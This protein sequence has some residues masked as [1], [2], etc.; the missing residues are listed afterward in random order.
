MQLPDPGADLEEDEGD[1][2]LPYQPKPNVHMNIIKL[3]WIKAKT[4]ISHL[5][6]KSARW[7]VKT[8]FFR[9]LRNP[10]KIMSALL[11]INLRNFTLYSKYTIY[12]YKFHHPPT[13]IY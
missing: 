10:E 9:S 7:T 5:R 2:S 12:A 6:V 1:A 4:A 8:F 3:I 13:K 11:I